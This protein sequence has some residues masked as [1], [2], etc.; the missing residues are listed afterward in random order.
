[1]DLHLVKIE[2]ISHISVFKERESDKYKY[3]SMIKRFWITFREEGFYEVHHIGSNEFITEKKILKN[4]LY[5]IWRKTVFV[6]QH[7]IIETNSGDTF[8]E[9]FET[10]DELKTRVG[11]ITNTNNFITIYNI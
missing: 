6:K 7:I 2:N 4:K 1:M 8:T 10:E 3:F 11:Q 5:R 9:I